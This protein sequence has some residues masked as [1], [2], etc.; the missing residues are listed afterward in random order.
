[1]HDN[2]SVTRRLRRISELYTI[3]NLISQ[4]P[5]A[6]SFYGG[7]WGEGG[8]GLYSSWT[9]FHYIIYLHLTGCNIFKLQVS[10]HSPITVFNL[11]FRDLASLMT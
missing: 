4:N 2:T 10:D 8:G 3:K 5:R 7:G 9:D 1:M 11:A 6:I